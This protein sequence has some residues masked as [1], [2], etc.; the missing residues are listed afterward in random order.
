M[1]HLLNRLRRLEIM[2]QQFGLES[3]ERQRQAQDDLFGVQNSRK[4]Y[5]GMLQGLQDPALMAQKEAAEKAL[6]AQVAEDPR[7]RDSADA[8]QRIAEVQQRRQPLLKQT[9]SFSSQ[10]YAIA[11]TLVL[12]AKEDQK[13][14][15]E[16]L[17]E[18]RDSN[19]ESLLQQLFSPAPIYVELDEAKL[20]DS[21]SWFVELRGGDDALVRQVLDGKSPAAR[22]AE[23]MA[24]TKLADVRSANNWSKAVWRPSRLRTIP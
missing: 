5:L 8:W 10:L 9:G 23:L 18:Y 20:A 6:L 15:A 17:R 11:E 4:A 22:A 12:L 13:P 21:L 16:R 19:R 14:S 2:Y 7:W 1:P 24:G 3:D